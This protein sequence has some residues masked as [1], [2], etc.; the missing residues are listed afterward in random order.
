MRGLRGAVL[1]GVLGSARASGAADLPAHDPL[2]ILLIADEVNP[3][4]LSDPEL[5]QPADIEAALEAGDSGL[6]LVAG[7]VQRVDSQCADDALAALAGADPPDV[8]IY[9]AHR[10]AHDC[11]G[12]D[13]QSALTDAVEQHLQRNGGVV[14]FHHGIYVDAGKEEILTLLGGQA[15]SIAWDTSTGQRVFAVG[16]DH[17]IASNGMDYEGSAALAGGG[18]VPGGTF[19]YFDDVPDE[20]Y[21]STVLL[22]EAGE[23]RDLLF[24]TDSGG[25]RVLGYALTRPGWAGRV[26]FWQP[27]EY[28]PN[29]LDDR[30]GNPFQVLANAIIYAARAEPGPGDDDPG[31]GCCRSETGAPPSPWLVL[32]VALAL[33]SKQRG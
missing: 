31:G 32:A 18:G 7:G 22:T 10:S 16:G 8:I 25:V 6:N 17:F 24:A 2:A 29:A 30:G 27:A 21:P 14:V 15:S 4:G 9:F 1:A 33:L 5:T 19:P 20:R 26:V 23:Q 13:V 11:L 12:G 3:H 28:Q